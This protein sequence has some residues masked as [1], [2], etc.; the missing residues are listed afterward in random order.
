MLV[1][2]TVV[3]TGHCSARSPQWL[4]GKWWTLKK[5]IPDYNIIPFKGQYQSYVLSTQND[6]NG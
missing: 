4:R 1:V 3:S 2:Y 6:D 5:N